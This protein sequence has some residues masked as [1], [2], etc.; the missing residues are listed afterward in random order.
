MK[1]EVDKQKSRI[2][3]SI[4]KIGIWISS[5]AAFMFVVAGFVAWRWVHS[6]NKTGLD[7][8]GNYGSYLQGTVASLWSLAGTLLIFVAFLAQK[9]QLLRQEIELEEQAKQFRIQHE[10]IKLQNFENSFFQLLN[11]HN[12]NTI[13][14]RISV[15]QF[16]GHDSNIYNGR[17]CFKILHNLLHAV[18]GSRTPEQNSDVNFAAEFYLRM[19]NVYE[20]SLG[21]YFR[22]LYHV[23]KFINESDALKSEDPDTDCKNRRRYTSLVRAQLSAFELELLFYNGIS[24]HGEK[25]K[26]LIEKFGLLENFDPKHLLNPSHEGFY[27]RIAFE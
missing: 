21:H 11:L 19:F 1:K 14:M 27:A 6:E 3:E 17:E 20:A 23:I 24:P 15:E 9:Q 4:L 8:W 22:T 12:Q 5:I 7:D 2:T 18:Y 13:Q 16:G 26:P 25:F 10:S